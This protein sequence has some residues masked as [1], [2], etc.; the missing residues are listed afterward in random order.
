VQDT[1]IGIPSEKLGDIFE[2]FYQVDSST[3]RQH[4]GQGVGL[5]ICQD[6]V[7]HHDGRIWA[8]NVEPQGTRITVLLPRRPAVLQPADP[9]SLTGLPFEAGELMERLMHW[10]SESLGI[11]V[12]AL[13]VPDKDGENLTIRAAIGL[14]E[15]VVQ[16]ARV[17]KGTGFA[18]RVWESGETLLIEDVTQDPRFHRELNEPRYSTRS[19]L[20]VPL[21]DGDIS[22]GVISV[23]NKI[24]GT[25][26][27]NDDKV[28]LE[29][30]A[31]RIT[32]LLTR[33]ESW[34]DGA[35][36]FDAIRDTLRSTTAVGHLRHESLLEVCQEICLASARQIMLPRE[37]LEHLAFTLQFYDV[38]LSSVPASILSKPGILDEEERWHVEQH[39]GA[40]LG[41]LG[42]L[43]LNARVRQLILHHHENY[44][45]TGYP[46]G[47]AGEAI[48]LGSRLVRLVDT[49]SSLL[50]RRPWRPP[51]NLDDAMDVIRGGIGREYC[52]RMADVFLAETEKRRQRITDLQAGNGAT[53]DLK[54]MPLDRGVPAP[55]LV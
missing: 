23:N 26:L 32:Q 38:G 34:Q 48:P 17:R 22:L 53:S 37:E 31:P 25:G 30:L 6:I 16:S 18:G 33:Y 12:A 51:M 2:S 40:G 45:G 10:V 46:M 47:L 54:R 3:T 35:R 13:M 52:P 14:P 50:S 15:A 27:D 4:N 41:I 29:S 5:A 8:E 19:L 21:K 36:D 44:D 7:R 49:L 24:D 43:Q 11:Q 55:L 42:S 28:F 20:C 9:D 39:V 1:G